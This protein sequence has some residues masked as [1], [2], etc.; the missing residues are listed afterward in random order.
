MKQL[1]A[2]AFVLFLFLSVSQTVHAT[3]PPLCRGQA[4]EQLSVN[5]KQ[6][7]DWKR[8]KPNQ[9]LERAR[10]RGIVERI[11]PDRNGHDHFEIQIGPDA[12]TD[13]VEV[14][15]NQA[16]G[17]LPEISRGMH[18][19]ACGDFIV[20]NAPTE[21]YPASPSGAVI[22]WVHANPHGRHASGYLWI[23]GVV[24]GQ[25]ARHDFLLQFL[26]N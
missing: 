16:F 20:S 7:L 1:N 19:E 13:T 8:A 5:N 26:D 10:L 6:A 14:V 2:F 12:R 21:K 22:H 4:G 24:F 17:R 3:N 15:Y 18:V 9:Y 25:I 23:D 11:F